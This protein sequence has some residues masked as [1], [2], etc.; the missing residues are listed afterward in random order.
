MKTDYRGQI[1]AIRHAM[2]SGEISYDEARIKAQPIIDEMN[3]KA[4]KVAEKF[5]KKHTNFTFN[6]LMR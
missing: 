5:G 4:R 1:E 3:V 6:Y 2:N